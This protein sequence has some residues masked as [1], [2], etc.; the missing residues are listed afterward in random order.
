MTGVE[1]SGGVLPTL[2]LAEGSPGRALAR[3]FRCFGVPFVIRTG[4]A[5]DQSL[6]RSSMDGLITIEGQQV[7]ALIVDVFRNR[8][9]E[10]CEIARLHGI[11]N[12]IVDIGRRG[13]D[14][15]DE[16][17]IEPWDGKLA[18]L[19]AICVSPEP[20]SAERLSSSCQPYVRARLRHDLPKLVRRP[21]TAG[22][23]E[24]LANA[25]ARLARR[26]MLA[27]QLETFLGSYATEN[28]GVQAL[29][30]LVWGK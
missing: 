2:L 26:R 8:A 27:L 4:D 29:I 18:S 12:P 3:V 23:S 28:E 9:R 17:L 1:T 21:G 11:R 16:L 22:L 19:I 25:R 10:F 5:D 7:G 24:F 30:Y 14:L 15:D 20:I 13:R 6:V